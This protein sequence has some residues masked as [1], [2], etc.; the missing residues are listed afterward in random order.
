MDGW[1]EVSNAQASVISTC[2]MLCYLVYSS[3]TKTFHWQDV[4]GSFYLFGT[5]YDQ[6]QRLQLP[7]FERHGLPPT[8][9]GVGAI[10]FDTQQD[11]LWIGTDSVSP[12]QQ[13][14]DVMFP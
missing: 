9:T 6:V 2:I 5:Y 1:G 7:L 10:L 12:D 3:S 11:L 4:T 8:P 13:I 14:S